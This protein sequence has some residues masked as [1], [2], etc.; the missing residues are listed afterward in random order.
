MQTTLAFWREKPIF[1]EKHVTVICFDNDLI[2]AFFTVVFSFICRSY[3]IINNGRNSEDFAQLL[4]S[5][6]FI[7]LYP[8]PVRSPSSRL[9]VRITA[10]VLPQQ[11]QR[12]TNANLFRMLN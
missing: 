9:E 4:Y 6:I 7:F 3:D 1:H 11:L 8:S 5:A 12:S 2:E 10:V